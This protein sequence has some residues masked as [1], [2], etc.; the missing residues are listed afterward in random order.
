MRKLALVL[1]LCSPLGAVTFG[2][3][4]GDGIL[5]VREIAAQIS[6]HPEG[7][8]M[9]ADYACALLLFNP[10]EGGEFRLLDTAPDVELSVDGRRLLGE[11]RQGGR[12]E[13]R[14]QIP[15]QGT[16]RVVSASRLSPR[17]L[18]QTH[19]LGVWRVEVP[20]AR[21]R[22][23]AAT[24]VSAAVSLHWRDIPA[25]CFG[26]LPGESSRRM[27]LDFTEQKNEPL[28]WKAISSAQRKEELRVVID[29]TEEDRRTHDNRLYTE[30]LV[31]LAE[32]LWLRGEHEQV[33][34]VCAELTR[35]E[36]AGGAAITHCGP[37][38][39]WRRHV[40]WP[41]QRLE[42]LDAAGKAT[43]AAAGIVAQ[44]TP[45]WEAYTRAKA[46][47][48]PFDDLGPARFGNYWDYDWHRTAR[49]YA[50]ALELSGK[51]EQAAAIIKEHE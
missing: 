12:T 8:Y 9:R 47:P 39:R 5:H 24:P 3:G 25:E 36:E 7:E 49:L 17:R 26:A 34:K 10:G 45:V 15:S 44:V 1:L 29:A 37:W 48:R 43:E 33:A 4:P 2:G 30:A 27:T 21:V 6:I 46:Q 40:P 42:A 16:L 19:V 23:F 38:A 51:P 20:L 28:E 22:G 31:T 13:W 50:R 18:P 11:R 35:L 41:L 32:V 14:V